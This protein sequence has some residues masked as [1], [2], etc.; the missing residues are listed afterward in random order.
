MAKYIRWEATISTYVFLTNTTWSLCMTIWY[1]LSK[2]LAYMDERHCL[3]RSRTF[4]EVCDLWHV[5]CCYVWPNIP[6]RLKYCITFIIWHIYVKKNIFL[7]SFQICL[8]LLH[9]RYIEFNK[10]RLEQVHS[11]ANFWPPPPLKAPCS[12]SPILTCSKTS[13]LKLS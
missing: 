6:N 7:F 3:Q 8:W 5:S 10:C 9:T 11:T 1:T 12:L 13:A 2:L 4:V